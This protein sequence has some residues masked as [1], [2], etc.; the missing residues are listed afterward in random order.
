MDN[1]GDWIYIVFLAIAGLSGL[2]S[3]ARKKK[4][5]AEA[6]M[7][8]VESDEL[9]DSEKGFWDMFEEMQ[10]KQAE[11]VSLPK[12]SSRP[13]ASKQKPSRTPFLTSESRIQS[14]SSIETIVSLEEDEAFA[15]D[16]SE[17]FHDPEEIRKAI[18]YTEIL[19]RKY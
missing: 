6:S 19:N 4:Q 1:L 11:P 3:S 5:E 2:I 13:S 17:D 12:Q 18:I 7:P 15:L 8:P 9:P 16:V 10:K 14:L